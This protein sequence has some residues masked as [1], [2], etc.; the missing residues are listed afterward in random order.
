MSVQVNLKKRFDLTGIP[1]A[2]GLAATVWVF[3]LAVFF[4]NSIPQVDFIPVVNFVAL[5]MLYAFTPEPSLVDYSNVD[6]GIASDIGK[7][8]ET[9]EMSIATVVVTY[10]ALLASTLLA[11]FNVSPFGSWIPLMRMPL[12]VVCVA[13]TSLIFVALAYVAALSYTRS[14]TRV[15]KSRLTNTQGGVLSRLEVAGAMLINA[16]YSVWLLFLVVG[17]LIAIITLMLSPNVFSA[18][19]MLIVIALIWGLHYYGHGKLFD[20]APG[21]PKDKYLKWSIGAF[22]FVVAGTVLN[23]LW[24]TQLATGRILFIKPIVDVDATWFNMAAVTFTLATAWFT[25]STPLF[26]LNMIAAIKDRTQLLKE[27]AMENTMEFLAF[28]LERAIKNSLEK[29][30]SG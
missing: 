26:A 12:P 6:A 10:V 18:L 27:V 22:L 29:S 19:N 7:I 8:L 5:I 24:L 25:L 21:M 4:P 9:S 23:W 28:I 15:V 11:W 16:A 3:F 17:T 1:A 13:E 14:L 20:E 2:L 30:L